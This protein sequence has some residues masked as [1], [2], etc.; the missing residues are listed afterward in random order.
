MKE[1]PVQLRMDAVLGSL[2]KDRPVRDLARQHAPLRAGDMRPVGG[3]FIRRSIAQRGNRRRQF[4]KAAPPH[5]D[6][7]EYRHTQGRS[8]RGGI[9]D[10]PVALGQIDHVERDDHRPAQFDDLLREHEVLLEVRCVE[11]DHQDVGLCLPGHATE[12]HVAGH[13]LVR[14]RGVQAVGTGQIDQFN[15]LAAGQQHAARFALDRHA[16]IVGDLLPR[17]GQRIE[18]R[19]LPGVGI[20]DQCGNEGMPGHAAAT[21]S[22]STCIARAWTRRSATVIRP[23]SMAMGSRARNTPR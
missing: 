10:E 23:I 15:G 8:E 20:A 11:D 22:G 14:A 7:R 3:R 9:D 1:Q 16:R 6:R 2:R 19:A 18:Q 13:F 17:A 5:G 21:V 4:R 12:N